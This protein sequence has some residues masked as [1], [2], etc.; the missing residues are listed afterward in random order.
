MAANPDG[1]LLALRLCDFVVQEP[2][3]VLAIRAKVQCAKEVTHVVVMTEYD[4]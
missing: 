2:R 1:L 3:R 4:G